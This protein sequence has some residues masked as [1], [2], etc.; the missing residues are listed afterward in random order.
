MEASLFFAPDL[1]ARWS[2]VR[3]T[4]MEEQAAP[5]LVSLL[6]KEGFGSMTL[7]LYATQIMK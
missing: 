4:K 3:K 1:A 7:S 5:D 2:T 6:E